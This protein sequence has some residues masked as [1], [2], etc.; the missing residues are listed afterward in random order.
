VNHRPYRDLEIVKIEQAF[1][2]IRDKLVKD[3]PSTGKDSGVNRD[4]FFNLLKEYG[5]KM[6]DKEISECLEVLKG[7]QNVKNL[8]D[9]LSFGYLFNEILKFEEMDDSNNNNNDEQ[10]K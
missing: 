4:L 9:Y 5:E 10:N 7:E 1:N 2:R 3:H 8:P 6:D